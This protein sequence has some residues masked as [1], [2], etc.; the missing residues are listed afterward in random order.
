MAGEGGE[1]GCRHEQ[2]PEM[3]AKR[4]SG[5]CRLRGRG[6]APD[7]PG[8]ASRGRV[9]AGWGAGATAGA[10]WV[11]WGAGLGVG[12]AQAGWGGQEAGTGA[13]GGLGAREE[14]TAVRAGWGQAGPAVVATAVVAAAVVAMGACNDVKAR[15]GTKSGHCTAFS[16][17]PGRSEWI[18][19]TWARN[20]LKLRDYVKKR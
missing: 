14:A 17:P 7:S 3:A 12:G 10:G 18:H 6:A 16:C 5:A 19:S 1:G 9:E 4:C 2:V 8:W 11:G 15:R 20:C 13:R